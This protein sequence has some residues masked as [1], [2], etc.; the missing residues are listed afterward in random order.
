[1]TSGSSGLPC[2]S[3]KENGGLANFR[4]CTRKISL[5]SLRAE[6]VASISAR[7]KGSNLNAC[8]WER[9]IGSSSDM[10]WKKPHLQLLIRVQEILS[11]KAEWAIVVCPL[12]SIVQNQ[13]IEASSMGLEA[14][15]LASARIGDVENGKYQLIF[16]S[17]EEIPSSLLS[18]R[19]ARLCTKTLPQ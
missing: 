3:V 19:A 1:M 17:V 8:S 16:A 14:T 18:Q 6:Y 13:L 10:L 15:S 7:T 12:K 4:C 5:I 9:F 2:F 11:S